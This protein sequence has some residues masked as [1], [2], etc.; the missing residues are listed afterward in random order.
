MPD[1]NE[2]STFNNGMNRKL[3]VMS[4][5]QEEVEKEKSSKKEF[6]TVVKSSAEKEIDK[7]EENYVT[8][9]LEGQY[10]DVKNQKEDDHTK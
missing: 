6:K 5:V 8:I 1:N 4:I 9:K 10:K 7:C 2:K 3:Y